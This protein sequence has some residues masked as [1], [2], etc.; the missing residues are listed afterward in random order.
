MSADASY[1]KDLIHME[2]TVIY[3]NMMY[4]EYGSQ[5]LRDL[6]C[7]HTSLLGEVL[8]LSYSLC[9]PVT[10]IRKQSS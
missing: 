8:L 7:N 9:S 10:V 1:I 3:C 5:N 4:E 6:I 2:Q